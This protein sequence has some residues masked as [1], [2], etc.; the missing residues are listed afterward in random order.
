M[1]LVDPVPDSCEPALAGQLRFTQR[2]PS[3]VADHDAALRAELRRNSRERPRWGYRRAH[4]LLL[5]D[6]WVLHQAHQRLWR[7]EGLGVPQKH[8]RRQ[9]LRGTNSALDAAAGRLFHHRRTTER[10]LPACSQLTAS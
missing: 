2:H 9:R 8:R 10:R 1:L 5:T 7:E 3:V 6:G 4:A